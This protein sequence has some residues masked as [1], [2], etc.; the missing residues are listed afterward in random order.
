MYTKNK[1]SLADCGYRLG[2]HDLSAMREIIGM[3]QKVEGAILTLPGIF[4]VLF[5]YDGFPVTYESG[6]HDIPQFDAHIEVY[7]ADKIVRVEFDSP[8]VKGLP[9]TLTV[10]ESIGTGGFQERK[11]RKTYEDPY[12]LEMLELHDCVINN[13]T[14]KSSAQDARKDVELFEMILKAGFAK[15]RK[16]NGD[17]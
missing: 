7:S 10:R 1:K 17:C 16:L 11:I 12:T 4:S 5:R 3:P 2:T 15:E 9:V 6:L 14:P 13:R 8:Y